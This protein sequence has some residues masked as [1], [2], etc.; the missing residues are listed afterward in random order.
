MKAKSIKGKSTEEINEAMLDAMA[1]GYQPTL[2]IIFISIKQ[3]RKA[4]ADLFHE[5]GIDILGATS[6]GEFIN[7]HQSEGETVIMLL[8][9]AKENYSI[10]Y[11]EIGE[12]SISD[13][14]A[15]LA[16][17]ALQ[18]FKNPSLIVCSTGMTTKAEYFDG[19]SMVKSIEKTLGPDKIFFGGMAGDDGT[20]SGSYI[21]NHE[22]ETD[23][24]ISALVLNGDSVSLQGKAIT[25]WKPMGIARTITKS[26]GSSIYTI[27]DMSAVDMYFKYLGREN[28]KTDR[29]FNLM[30]ELGFSYPF[31]TEREPGGETILITPRGIDYKD[32]ALIVDMPTKEGTKLWFSMPPEFEI[33]EEIIDEANQ[34]KN[35]SELNADALLIFSCAGRQPVLGPL[36]TAENEGLQEVWKTPM[37]GFFTYGEIG[38]TKKGK[39][40]YHSGACCWV[41][42]KEK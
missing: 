2:A 21:F 8:D 9:I 10:L 40:E 15:Q 36:T 25:G 20:F 17:N 14:A 27:D 11:E 6:C 22:K 29:L 7:G 37:A 5:K 39:Q 35:N 28:K 33:V 31:I 4:V 32:N 3:D 26:T 34:L 1:D 13:A 16:E 19:P 30:D 38:R 24:G 23:F 18:K 12:R 42:I 41:A